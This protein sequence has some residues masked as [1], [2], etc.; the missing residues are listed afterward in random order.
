MLMQIF[1]EV[2]ALYYGIVQVENLG[3]T[4]RNG[5]NHSLSFIIKSHF[6]RAINY[7]KGRANAFSLSS[8]TSS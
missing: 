8:Q 6:V 4:L 1:W 2:E 5:E 3:N 7:V